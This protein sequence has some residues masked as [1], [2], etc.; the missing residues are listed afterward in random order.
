LL[1]D[2]RA[3]ILDGTRT[4]ASLCAQNLE[5]HR[6]YFWITRHISDSVP[7]YVH[8]FPKDAL[9]NDNYARIRLE[10]EIELEFVEFDQSIFH[11]T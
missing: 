5:L 2:G 6:I 10:I 11:Q 3:C 8:K 7:C 4:L 1:I 9:K